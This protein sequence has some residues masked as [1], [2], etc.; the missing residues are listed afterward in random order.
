MRLP[1]FLLFS[2][3]DSG[4]MCPSC[5]FVAGLPL[6]LDFVLLRPCMFAPVSCEHSTF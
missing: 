2:G 3:C 1:M 6:G 5:L 4:N